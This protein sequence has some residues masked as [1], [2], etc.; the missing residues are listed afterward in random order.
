ME[1]TL[2]LKAK[3]LLKK[4]QIKEAWLTLLSFND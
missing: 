1:D 3:E 4:H 2:H